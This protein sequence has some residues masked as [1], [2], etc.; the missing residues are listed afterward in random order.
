[1]PPVNPENLRWARV[2][3]GLSLDDAARLLGLAGDKGSAR[4]L[5]METGVRE[6]TRNQLV[7]MAKKYRR[8]LLALYVD[9]PPPAAKLNRDLRRMRDPDDT[10]E[11]WL[12]AMIRNAY[13]RHALLTS[14][15]EDEEEGEPLAFVGSAPQGS[16]ASQLVD[17]LE[18]A[19]KIN[20]DDFRSKGSA[21]AAFDFLRSKVENLGAFVLLMGN[22]GNY[23]TSLEPKVFRGFSI[24]QPIAP[25]I[26]INDTDSK[27]A[28]SFTLLHEL[29][30]VFLGQSDISGYGSKDATERLCDDV[31]ARFLLKAVDL[32]QL[33]ITDHTP[34]ETIIQRIGQT[35]EKLKVSRKMLAYNLWRSG[36]FRAPLYERLEERF[37][38]DREDQRRQ[39]KEKAKGGADYYVVKRHRLGSE[40]V[41][42]VDRMMAAGAL[43]APKAAQVLGVRPTNV[44][45]LV[46]ELA[47]R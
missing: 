32:D 38:R 44:P 26:V 10:K 5:E 21:A 27:A 46:S 25:F 43:T 4:L 24:A 18:G 37:D 34:F 33:Q 8:P 12:H 30:H 39:T 29:A 11:A 14:A 20:I 45:R 42:T 16:N 3:A 6:P 15:L 19:L 17:R 36:H 22:L 23:Q 28:W 31:A 7:N 1:M 2:T 13:V 41:K 47:T 40:L 9:G 35:A